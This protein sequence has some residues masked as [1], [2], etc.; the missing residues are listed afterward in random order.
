MTIGAGVADHFGVPDHTG[1]R[2][3]LAFSIA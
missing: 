3:R 1:S 2:S